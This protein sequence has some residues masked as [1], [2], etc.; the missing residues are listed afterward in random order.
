MPSSTSV[1]FGPDGDLKTDADIDDFRK[2]VHA[3]Q[4]DVL[5]HLKPA[6]MNVRG[7]SGAAPF[8]ADEKLSAIRATQEFQG[9]GDTTARP[10][11]VTAP[12]GDG[13]DFC[14]VCLSVCVSVVRVLC[15]VLAIGSVCGVH[16]CWLPQALVLIVFASSVCV[17]ACGM[18]VPIDTSQ[19]RHQVCLRLWSVGFRVWRGLSSQH[20]VF[21]FFLSVCCR[22]LLQSSAIVEPPLPSVST[23]FIPRPHQC[24]AGD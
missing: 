19:P 24:Q 9:L 13:R 2:V 7:R 21:C 10:F 6:R 18:L 17:R 12:A 11:V 8:A 5:S 23:S 16:C 3:D 1:T 14:C 22:C 15:I 20:P 4:S